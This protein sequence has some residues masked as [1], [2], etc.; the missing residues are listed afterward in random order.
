K[1]IAAVRNLDVTFVKAELEELSLTGLTVGFTINVYN[2][3]NLNVN[4]GNLRAK[5]FANNVSLAAV[6]LPSFDLKAKGS[7]QHHFSVKLGYWD[8]GSA[9]F[10]AIKEWNLSWRIEGVYELRLPF[11]FVYPYDFVIQG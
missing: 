2:P 10:N 7:L 5:I 11:G 9:L 3:N 8:L 4:V 6:E 1:K